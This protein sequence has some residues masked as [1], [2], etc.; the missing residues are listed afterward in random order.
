MDTPTLSPKRVLTPGFHGVSSNGIPFSRSRLLERPTLAVVYLVGVTLASIFA[1]NTGLRISLR[2][3]TASSMA[4][5]WMFFDLFVVELCAFAALVCVL[6]N[7]GVLCRLCA[8]LLSTIF[9]L[10]NCVQASAMLFGG[11][12]ISPLALENVAH[13]DFFLSFFLTPANVVGLSA[14]LGICAAFPVVSETVARPAVSSPSAFRWMTVMFLLGVLFQQS[15]RWL[16]QSVIEARGDLQYRTNMGRRSPVW[17]LALAI[18]PRNGSSGQ[19]F[20]ASEAQAL[21]ELGFSLNQDAPLP[22]V[23]DHV[24]QGAVPFQPAS[25]GRTE[26]PNVLLLVPDGISSRSIA[27][28]HEYPGLTPNLQRFAASAMSVSNYYNHTAATYRGLLGQ[29]CSV[30]PLWDGIDKEAGVLPSH[31]YMCLQDLFKEAGYRTTFIDADHTEKSFL[32]EM[33]KRLRF[34]NVLSGEQIARNYLNL[35]SFTSD[36]NF[37]TDQQFFR[38]VER[39][40]RESEVAGPERTPFFAVVYSV[41]THAFVDIREDGIRYG[42]GSNNALN[43]IRTFDDA[44]GTFLRYFEASPYASTTVLIVTSDHAHYSENTFVAAFGNDADYQRLFVDKI[45]LMIRDPRRQL[46]DV[47]DPGVATSIDFAPSIAHY[48]G[49][50]ANR[51]NPFF[52]RS[53]F[54][55]RTPQRRWG[56]ASYDDNYYMIERGRVHDSKFPERNPRE[57][58]LFV[59]YIQFTYLQEKLNRIW[60]SDTPSVNLA[61]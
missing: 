35:P 7:G 40:L 3:T 32:D 47:Y 46:P 5:H 56:F 22:F 25:L 43:T 50:P 17:A 21:G 4:A 45:P 52:G 6:V 51:R 34:D 29:L 15:P 16:P 19:A 9:V 31:D 23:R 36:D 18:A 49:L 42:D 10:V 27:R 60:R 54:E 37:L 55:M 14:A 1:V 44:F 33:M 20:S 39:F 12:Y 61:D 13:L 8:Y 24:Y 2:A 53:I 57:M 41:E 11:E 28:D 26:R 48:L 59:R 38:G 30:F 58:D